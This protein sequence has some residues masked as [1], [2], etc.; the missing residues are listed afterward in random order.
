MSG[1]QLK[2]MDRPQALLETSTAPA[3]RLHWIST[4]PFLIGLLLFL[5]A[6]E[7]T[8]CFYW[9]PH[10]EAQEMDFRQ[11][12]TAG[13]ILRTEPSRLYD[14]H[15]QVELQ[16]ALTGS[17]HGLLL[18]NHTPFEA[19]LFLPLSY[20]SYIPAYLAMIAVEALFIG[21]CF[22]ALPSQFSTV[23]PIWQPRPGLMFFAFFPVAICVITGQDSLLFLAICCV[24]L[25]LLLGEKDFWAGILL[26]GAIF[27]PQ[28]ALP[29]V[30]LIF[31]RR[32]WRFLAGFGTGS[33]LLGLISLQL[34]HLSG[35][36]GFFRAIALTNM[37]SKHAAVLR[38]DPIGTNPLCMPNLHG[39]LFVSTFRW[40][41]HGVELPLVV[42]ASLA[43]LFWAVRRIR[44]ISGEETAFAYA[45][46]WAILLS[47]LVHISDLPLWLLPLTILLNLGGDSRSKL[48]I[49]HVAFIV[50]AALFLL[51]GPVT[52]PNPWLWILSLP[53]FA[54]AVLLG[55]VEGTRSAEP[56][57]A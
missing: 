34:V 14:I 36:R 40:L 33:A 25:R 16:T 55:R 47:Y 37:G 26:A 54:T 31:A 43:A 3:A 18:F 27:K 46:I 19:L 53:L 11:F 8:A 21:A 2:A 52:D 45:M 13:Y 57:Q 5:A 38:N 48:L 1:F 42:V 44:L 39:L 22:C 29:L 49:T 32:G 35:I 9:L 6:L 41:P 51:L 17:P 10:R 12:Y 50:P 20:L 30:I 28:L 4:R 24:T 7:A 56:V 15:R 23:I